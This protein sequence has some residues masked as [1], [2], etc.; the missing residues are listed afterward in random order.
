M[1]SDDG[2]SKSATSPYF[3]SANDNPGNIITQVQLKGDNYDEWARAMRTALRAKKKFGFIDGSVIQP[4]D[5]SMTQEDWWTV[6]SMLISWILNTIEPT[7]RSTITYREVAKELWDDIKERFSA[8]NG[9]R[10]HQLK[11]ELAECKQQG[12]TVMSYY[13]KL[14]MIWEELGNYEQYPTCRC[15]GCACNIGAELDKR[16]E[17]ERLHQFFMGLDD[18]TYGTVRS[19]ILSTEPLPTL[20]RAYAMIIQE[21]R[22]CSITRGKEQQVEAMAFAVQ[23]A[24]SLKGRTE[25]KDKTVLCSNCKRTGH[26]AESCFQL[27][28]YPNWW[29]DRPRGGGGR[30]TGRGQGGQKQPVA[31]GGRGRGEQI[32]ANAAQVTTQGST[33]QE[34]RVEGDKNGLNGLSNEQWNLLLNLLNR[35]KEGNQGRLNGKHKIMEWI[36]DSGASHHMTGSLKS[37]SDVKKILSC[38]VGLPDGKET[39]A[40]KEGTIDHNSRMLIGAGE[41]REGLYYFRSLTSVKVMKVAENDSVDLWHRR[42]VVFKEHVF[43]YENKSTSEQGKTKNNELDSLVAEEEIMQGAAVSENLDMEHHSRM[44]HQEDQ[45]GIRDIDY[46][47]STETPIYVEQDQ[48]IS[49]A[50]GGA[51]ETMDDEQSEIVL[52]RGCRQRQQSTRFSSSSPSARSPGRTHSSG[53]P[54]PITH[55]V[56]YDKFSLRHRAFLAAVTVALGTSSNGRA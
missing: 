24:T 26:V 4:S 50:R 52:G 12:I 31:S 8:G 21:E 56:N 29:G 11:S 5:D 19:N 22:V 3:L 34:Q 6:N 2:P 49:V 39:I 47:Q 32:R 1:L 23:I 37:M 17:E 28:G 38:P 46:G 36:I 9:P 43:P 30:G 33:A 14:K 27:I 44:P 51:N 15:G 42:D 25:S 54:Y 18:S 55:Y 7:L 20:N 16:R 10:V 13:G 40:E 41:Q 35:Q 45:E 48:G 53:S